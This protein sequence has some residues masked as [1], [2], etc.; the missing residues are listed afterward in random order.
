PAQPSPG[1]AGRRRLSA[2]A[3]GGPGPNPA[4]REPRMRAAFLRRVQERQSAM[5][6]HGGV[7]QPRQGI[8]PLSTAQGAPARQRELTSGSVQR[9]SCATGADPH[10]GPRA[11]PGF[12]DVQDGAGR[13]TAE[14]GG[15]QDVLVSAAEHR[16]KYLLTDR[17]GRRPAAFSGGASPPAKSPDR[18]ASTAAV[19]W[20]HSQ[21]AARFGGGHC[22]VHASPER[23]HRLPPHRSETHA[24]I[25][26]TR[27]GK[28]ERSGTSPSAGRRAGRPVR[29]ASPPPR[30]P[31]GRMAPRAPIMPIGPRDGRTGRDPAAAAGPPRS[32]SRRR[33]ERD[34]AVEGRGGARCSSGTRQR[35]GDA[36]VGAGGRLSS[37]EAFPPR[38][39]YPPA[40]R[41]RSGHAGAP[42]SAVPR[43]CRASP[44]SKSMLRPPKSRT[45]PAFRRPNGT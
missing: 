24:L 29:S 8:A 44:A 42:A 32:R 38:P 20:S 40:G 18:A 7:R 26:F 16:A 41:P 11:H 17:R 28:A 27:A 23:G 5:V 43:A 12:A 10:G 2:P 22:P 19:T 14:R 4:L 21:T 1:L 25:P 13:N 37:A 39:R 31:M 30:C 36:A 9:R 45:P 3:G 34:G 15:G 6:L 35:D 33:A